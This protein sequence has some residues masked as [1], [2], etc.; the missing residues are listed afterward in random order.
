MEKVKR[1]KVRKKRIKTSKT[2]KYGTDYSIILPVL[3]LIIVGIFM[4]FSASSIQ[5]RVT[6]GDELFFLKRQV[7]YV[8]AGF[9]VMI[10]ASRIPFKFYH[11]NAMILYIISVILLI[12]TRFTPLGAEIN[13]TK[14]WIVIDRISF[15]PSELTKFANI[16]FLA[17]FIKFNNNRMRRLDTLIRAI[18]IIIIPFM[19]ILI[20]P[21]FSAAL[22]IGATGFVMLFISGISL[23]HT[24]SITIIGV[25]GATLLALAKPYRVERLMTFMNP[26][27]NVS[28]EGWQVVNSLLAIAS[29]GINGVGYGKSI[30]KFFYI[31][32]PQNDFIFAV[33]AEEFG[34]IGSIFIIIIYIFLL[35]RIFVLFENTKDVFASIIVLGIGLQIGIQM[36]MNIAVAIS[37]IPN[38]GV[39]LPFISYGGTSVVIFMGMVGVLLNISRNRDMII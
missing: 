1:K 5:A 6:N 8:L 31:S 28:N 25:I 10:M 18:I 13:E 38:T 15:Q 32:Q 3:A 22:T 14:R 24:L 34:F 12:L 36:F 37:L 11:D 19:L 7:I 27:E 4:I 35:F 16:V 29:G 23:F 26:F 9:I 17:F 39:G 21:S 2:K 33:I 30:Q 20:Q